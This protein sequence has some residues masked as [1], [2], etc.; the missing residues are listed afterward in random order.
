MSV[1]IEFPNL[2]ATIHDVRKTGRAGR[3][4]QKKALEAAGAVLK[5]AVRDHLSLTGK[6]LKD[7]AQMD[8]PYATRHGSIQI[9][10][11]RPFMVHKRSGQMQGS[12]LLQTKAY[13]GGR[14]GGAKYGVKV[15]LD[16][17][18]N[19]YFAY[20]IQ[21]TRVMLPRDTIYLTSQLPEVQQGMMRAV[22]RVLG[23]EMRSQA[24]VRF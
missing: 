3:V 15:G 13:P 21:G 9:N 17:A 12:V 6:S 14:G 2:Q 8:H 23:P 16:Y 22:V 20:V 4:A 1:T 11:Q 5:K 24:P 18:K 10:Q 7:L 19:R